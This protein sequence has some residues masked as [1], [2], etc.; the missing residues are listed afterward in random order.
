[1]LIVDAAKYREYTEF[2]NK[3]G[4]FKFIWSLTGCITLG[5][6]STPTLFT[7]K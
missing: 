5:N 2:G 6:C 4:S 1:M 3:R 7:I